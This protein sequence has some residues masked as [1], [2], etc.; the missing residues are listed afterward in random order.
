M[1]VNSSDKYWEFDCSHL[2]QTQIDYILATVLDHRGI[3][4]Q[5]QWGL[6]VKINLPDRLSGIGDCTHARLQR[7]S[8]IKKISTRLFPLTEKEYTTHKLKVESL[9][10]RIDLKTYEANMQEDWDADCLEE[11]NEI[12]AWFTRKDTEDDLAEFLYMCAINKQ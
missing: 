6:P 12:L 3:I 7:E 2:N 5:W 9:S 11:E 8:N 10:V 4:H 1:Q